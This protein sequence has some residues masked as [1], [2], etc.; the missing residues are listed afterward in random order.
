MP[1]L[2]LGP[3]VGFSMKQYDDAIAADVNRRNLINGDFWNAVAIA[4]KQQADKT[5][6]S[7]QDALYLTTVESF[8]RAKAGRNEQGGP[9]YSPFVS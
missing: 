9:V 6:L 8:S 7:V 1:D 5:H 2:R 4:A 3:P